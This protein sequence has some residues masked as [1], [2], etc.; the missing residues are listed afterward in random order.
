MF[1]NVRLL[2]AATLAS[3]V[4]LICGFGMFATLRVSHAPLLR[5]LVATAS[6]QR[7]ADNAASSP[8][9]FA[10]LEPFDRRFEI[11]THDRSDTVEAFTRFLARRE[12]IDSPPAASPAVLEPGAIAA[13]EQPTA[14]ET[15][16][17]V[18]AAPGT[19]AEASASIA[20]NAPVASL[21]AA[22]AP[23][24]EA[25]TPTAVA[26]A[27]AADP[28][29]PRPAEPTPV[30]ATA[31]PSAESEERAVMTAPPAAAAPDDEARKSEQTPAN[32]RQARSVARSHRIRSATSET[33]TQEQRSTFSTAPPTQQWQTAQTGPAKARRRSVAARKADKSTSGVGG[34]FASA[35][36]Q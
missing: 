32:A 13:K 35:P 11:G 25:E 10:P 29:P 2:V 31:A 33:A 9:A 34:P 4:M 15:P 19:P 36:S 20:T 12:N 14:I 8:L 23:P 7:L 16:K 26:P 5:P 17:N 22:T 28:A 27:A 1:P 21:P 18:P 24:A 30:T 6:P 3:I